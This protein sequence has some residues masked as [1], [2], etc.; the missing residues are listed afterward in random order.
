MIYDC[1]RRCLKD[2]NHLQQPR[3]DGAPIPGQVDGDD[4]HR[5]RRHAVFVVKVVVIDRGV[6]QHAFGVAVVGMGGGVALSDGSMRPYRALRDI[7]IEL[8]HVICHSLASDQI[9]GPSFQNL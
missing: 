8:V 7:A 9:N 2:F 4:S 6:E 5:V 1:L 3:F